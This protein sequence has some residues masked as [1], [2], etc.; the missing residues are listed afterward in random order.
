MA[1]DFKTEKKRIAKN[2]LGFYFPQKLINSGSCNP[3]CNFYQQI[4][5]FIASKL[6]SY[7]FFYCLLQ[8]NAD[9]FV[10]AAPPKT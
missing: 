5:V 6:I 7:L 1:A 9:F 3:T 10:Q 2:R 8:K 4:R